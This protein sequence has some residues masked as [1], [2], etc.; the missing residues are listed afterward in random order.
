MHWESDALE[1]WSHRHP[2]GSIAQAW[3]VG[4]KHEQKWS[5]SHLWEHF[6]VLEHRMPIWLLSGSDLTISQNPCPPRNP[7][8]SLLKMQ[9]LKLTQ[10]RKSP[11][12]YN[13]LPKMQFLKLNHKRK[14]PNPYNSLL[15]MQLLKLTQR[16][17]SPNPYNSLLKMQFFE[18]GS[19]TKVAKPL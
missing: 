18:I 9:F 2:C 4:K 17:R 11:N 3:I 7:Y 12:P 8:N 5:I 1:L 13:S 16:R 10:R 14:S 15:K 6:W 19:Q